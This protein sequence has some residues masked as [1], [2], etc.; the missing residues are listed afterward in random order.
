MNERD[1][2]VG[3]IVSE[4]QITHNNDEDALSITDKEEE[5]NLDESADADLCDKNFKN[6]VASEKHNYFFNEHA[7]EKS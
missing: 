5:S 2:F 1:D 7:Q 6:L 3:S 4:D